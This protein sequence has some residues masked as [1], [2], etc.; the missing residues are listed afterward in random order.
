VSP[1]RL[2]L[3]LS[4]SRNNGERIDESWSALFFVLLRD[5]TYALAML[6]AALWFTVTIGLVSCVSERERP[7][8]GSGVVAGPGSVG[9]GGAG[10]VGGAGGT[11]SSG[12]SGGSTST[13]GSGGSGGS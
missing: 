9:S 3:I 1:N 10:G 13:G 6:R 12:G 4:G 5:S 8:T 11:M 7:G 2:H